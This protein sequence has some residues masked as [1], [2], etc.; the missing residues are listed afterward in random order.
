MS[1]E[2]PQVD[3]DFSLAGKVAVVTGAGSGLGDAITRAFAAKGARVALLDIDETAAAEVAADVD[4]RAFGCDVADPDSVTAAV[5]A[6][7]AE[8]G[9][10]DILVNSAGI[11]RLAPAEDISFADWTSTI[12]INLTGSF[13]VAQAAGRVMLEKGRG[14]I[15]NIASQAGHVALDKHVA[16][17]ASKAAIFGLTK[18][19]ASEWGP[20]G[21]TCNS[22]SPTVVLTPL[23]AEAWTGPHG[24]AH[25]AQIP[26]ERFA[27]P[28]EIA[29]AALYLVSDAAAMV[30]GADLRIDGGFT[31]R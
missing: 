23:G 28:D 15:L 24:D 2:E 5:G 14:R 16:Y 25:K 17:T 19:L 8:F 22:L 20:S 12:D 9:T 3:F 7:V 26:A 27:Y 13:L 29:A 31:I 4:G 21:I 1:T 30:N 10:I 6:V 11:A 18:T